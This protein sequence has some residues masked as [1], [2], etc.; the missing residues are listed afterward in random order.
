YYS[1]FDT[2]PEITSDKINVGISNCIPNLVLHV[3]TVL[4]YD[5]FEWFFN[6]TSIP[7]ATSNSYSPTEPGF[8]QV[9][10]SIS[11]CGPTAFSDIIPV[12]NCPTDIDND[13]VNDNI[14]L[15][16]DN[17]GITNC[18]ESYG[19]QNINITNLNSGNISIGGYS[20]SF[21]GNVTTLTIASPTHFK[22]NS[23]GS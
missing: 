6:N 19:N 14:D 15:D 20:N 18:T 13:T 11:G 23:D 7:N 8:Y 5:T 12:S 3:S 1:G 17:D 16:N 10:A 2:K 21:T 9:K 4:N 22:G